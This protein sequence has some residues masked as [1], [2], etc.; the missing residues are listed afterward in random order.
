MGSESSDSYPI[1]EMSLSVK[2]NTAT[3]A[4]NKQQMAIGNSGPHCP[5]VTNGKRP[6]LTEFL[7]L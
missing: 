4:T 3:A 2:D 1:G 6:P 5:Q 7:M